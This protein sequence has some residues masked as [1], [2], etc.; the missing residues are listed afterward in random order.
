LYFKA[1]II[2][3]DVE[4]A[5]GYYENRFDINV[6]DFGLTID[7]DDI[8]NT[9]RILKTVEIMQ[10]IESGDMQKLEKE[11]LY[12]LSIDVYCDVSEDDYC[13]SGWDTAKKVSL[14]L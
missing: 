4:I 2:P 1:R 12:Q 10:I 11:I 14:N 6:L 3:I 7:L 13:F 9:P 8:D 5:L